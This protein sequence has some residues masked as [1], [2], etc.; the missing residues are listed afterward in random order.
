[1][2]AGHR[3]KK[4]H[5]DFLKLGVLFIFAIYFLEIAFHHK[6]SR[7]F[8]DGIDIRIVEA[9]HHYFMFF[10]NRFLTVAGGT[11]LQILIPVIFVAY[12]YLTDQKY[13]AAIM[14]LWLGEN[15]INAS[16]YIADAA[17]MQL[18]LV[19]GSAEGHDWNSLLGMLGALSLTNDLAGAVRA[20]GAMIIA[21][22]IFWGLK[23]SQKSGD[24]LD[25]FSDF[26]FEQ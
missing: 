11:I 1:M 24:E 22:A 18:P 2:K 10:G 9:G 25:D 4:T 19:G 16:A 13:F 20:L 3:N 15:F 6:N 7:S 21:A 8:I 12:F 5:Y 14:T 26:S 17:K 23:N